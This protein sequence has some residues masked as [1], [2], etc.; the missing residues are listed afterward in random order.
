LNVKPPPARTQIPPHKR[1]A[2]RID[3]GSGLKTHF[4]ESRSQAHCLENSN[5]ATAGKKQIKQVGKRPEVR[6]NFN[7]ELAMLAQSQKFWPP[8]TFWAGYTTE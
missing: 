3:D 5:T 2:P 4:C 8:K 7:F 1:E 6:N